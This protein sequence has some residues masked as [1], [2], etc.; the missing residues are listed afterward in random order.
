MNR[1]TLSI[2]TGALTVLVLGLSFLAWAQGIHGS[3]ERYGLFP[4]LGLMAWS[5][6]WMHYVSGSLK[7]YLGLAQDETI[8]KR[9]FTITSLV[10][11]VL[12][13]LHP[14][15]LYTNLFEDGYGLPPLSAFMAY[16]TAAARLALVFGGVSLIA[17]LLFE[18]GRWFRTKSW[19]KYIEYAS[20]GAMILI[21]VHALLIGGALL[22]GW[23]RFVW[24]GLGWILVMSF[25][26]NYW[27]DKQ[28]H[29][30]TKTSHG[31]ST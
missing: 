26:Y 28:Y 18:L 16:P 10:V 25:V 17:F 30:Q 4:L 29:N 6:M 19:W 14:A 31:D 1:V 22:P 11:L 24:I 2:A 3:I 13:L 23:F 20:M 27:Y 15:I 8:L 12:I 7:R 5:L 21:F 9:Y